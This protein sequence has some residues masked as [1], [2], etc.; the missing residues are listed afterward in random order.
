MLGIT[1]SS[2]ASSSTPSTVL[3]QKSGVGSDSDTLLLNQ[4]RLKL[5]DENTK[6]QATIDF[7]RSY[8]DNVVQQTSPFGDKEQNKLTFE[9]VNLAKNLI[10]FGFYSFKD[11]LKLTKTLLEI[12]DRDDHTT[13]VILTATG[14]TPEDTGKL[15]FLSLLFCC[16]MFP[17]HASLLLFCFWNAASI[18]TTT[19]RVTTITTTTATAAAPSTTTATKTNQA[20]SHH[21]VAYQRSN[22]EKILLADAPPPP[23]SANGDDPVLPTAATAAMN[24]VFETKIKIID[25]FQVCILLLFLFFVHN[26]SAQKSYE[27]FQLTKNRLRFRRST[28]FLCI[29]STT[30]FLNDE[31]CEYRSE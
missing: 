7:V 9:V 3:K 28:L 8:L 31:M 22:T 17:P 18:Q 5:L 10:Y 27:C 2:S 21:P 20:E 13:N 29:V 24:L 26:L 14:S 25:I 16:C 11:L 15:P 19:T 1:S 12:L 4:E 30:P 6:F 23:A